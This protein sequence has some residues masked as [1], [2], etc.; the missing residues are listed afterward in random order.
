MHMQVVPDIVTQGLEALVT[1][2][3]KCPSIEGPSLPLA[4]LRQHAHPAEQAQM[5][6]HTA[7]LAQVAHGVQELHG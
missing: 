4:E 7:R 1:L 5:T 3:Q 6:R 2:D